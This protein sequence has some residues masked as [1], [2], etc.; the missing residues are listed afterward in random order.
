M[1]LREPY[2]SKNLKM[3]NMREVVVEVNRYIT[4]DYAYLKNKEK[5]KIKPFVGTE[6]ELKPVVLYGIT[7]SE[8]EIIPLTH[9]FF[10]KEN[11]WV[12]LDLRNFVK[13]DDKREGYEIRN[14]SEY[15]LALIKYVLSSLWSV[16]KQSSLYSLEL[17]HFSFASWLSDNLASKFGLEFGD[18][19]R[20]RTLAALYYSRMFSDVHEDDELDKLL[21]RGKKDMIVPELLK[22]IYEKAGNM[23]TIEGFCE[24]CYEVTGNVRLKGLDYV[25][26]SNIISGNWLG[27]HGKELSLLALEHPPTWVALVY[28]SITQRSYKRSF[29]TTIVEKQSKRGKDVDYV[30]QVEILTKDQFEE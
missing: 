16:G 15:R 12:V 13:V 10:S 4:L 7:E 22:E 30:R 14:E 5:V 19:V 28:A 24:M 6:G 8:R 11:A 17:A 20:L 26:L 1:I 29:I 21:I 25:V 23:N 27:A 18:K 2:D 3:F 9:P